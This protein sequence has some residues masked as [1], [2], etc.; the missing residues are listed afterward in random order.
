MRLLPS[1][2]RPLNARAA[3]QLALALLA[4]L[5]VLP[6]LSGCS[7]PGL[8]RVD[9][10]W[11]TDP[12]P[13]WGLYPGYRQEIPCPPGARYRV[14]AHLPG[15]VVA[16]GYVK[17]AG[18]SGITFEADRTAQGLV[19]ESDDANVLLVTAQTPDT[20]GGRARY[21]ALRVERKGDKIV[22]EFPK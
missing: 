15:K 19:A 14:D 2:P 21:T 8:E 10:T 11:E 4:A 3:L 22:F 20:G 7:R 9:V 5:A 16:S 13:K 6:V 1:S 12:P 17:A 18:A